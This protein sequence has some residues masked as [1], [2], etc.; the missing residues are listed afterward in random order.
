AV[1]QQR[2]HHAR[3]ACQ[4]ERA[5]RAEEE[6]GCD[7]CRDVDVADLQITRGEIH[8]LYS[9]VNGASMRCSIAPKIELPSL[10]SIS[11]LIRSPYFRNGVLGWPSRSVSTVRCSARQDAPFEVS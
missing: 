4:D 9:C 3:P 11:I 10:S 1:A 6:A 7:H 2:V 8:A 5:A